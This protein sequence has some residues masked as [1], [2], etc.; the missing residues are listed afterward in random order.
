MHTGV[1]HHR[2]AAGQTTGLARGR[3]AVARTLAH[4]DVA[5]STTVRDVADLLDADMD[6]RAGG[7]GA[8]S[9]A[10]PR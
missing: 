2:S 5:P 4:T 1:A 8:H 10:P 3:G 6:K 7:R 9:G